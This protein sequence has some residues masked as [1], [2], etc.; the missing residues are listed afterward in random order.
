MEG[1]LTIT[2]TSDAFL[3]FN[4]FLVFRSSSVVDSGQGSLGAIP[5]SMFQHTD[6]EYGSLDRESL[7]DNSSSSSKAIRILKSPYVPSEPRTYTIG[8]KVV[9]HWT[10]D[11]I[12]SS[13]VNISGSWLP[14][15]VSH[16]HEDGTLDVVRIRCSS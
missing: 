16:V 9:A 2:S 7:P 8:Q 11:G 1:S 13:S 4:F 15:T 3:F 10:N 6:V 12:S 5:T 14:A